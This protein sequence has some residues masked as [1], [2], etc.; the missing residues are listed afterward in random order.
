M[1]YAD[2]IKDLGKNLI[3]KLSKHYLFIIVL[4]LIA[5]IVAGVVTVKTGS[6]LD[7][8]RLVVIWFILPVMM[9]LFGTLAICFLERPGKKDPFKTIEEPNLVRIENN[10][11]EDL[12][13]T[14][15]LYTKTK[16]F[17]EFVFETSRIFLSVVGFKADRIQ[18]S[19]KKL[20]G[21]R[22]CRHI[23]DEERKICQELKRKNA[24]SSLNSLKNIC[25]TLDPD[26]AIVRL[27]M[28]THLLFKTRL[29][30]T[31]NLRI[32]YFQF[33]DDDHDYLQT[34][35]SWNGT[36]LNCV[37]SPSEK[38]REKFNM[39]SSAAECL[40]V[41]VALSGCIEP[42]PYAEDADGNSSHPFNYF[43]NEQ[44]EHIK[45]LVVIPLKVE[46]TMPDFKP[47]LVIDSDQPGFFGEFK[48]KEFKYIQTNLSTR[49]LM[50]VDMKVLLE[51]LLKGEYDNDNYDT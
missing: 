24:C 42:V 16:Q 34:P 47:L 1:S 48:E 30:P 40:A 9:I 45:S 26:E 4:V 19:Y 8:T 10:L 43:G 11:K 37:R 51:R 50:E 20:T 13:K 38:Y 14:K 21:Q 15:I 41:S 31:S 7:T 22:P 44:R 6:T 29:K 23:T 35:L 46:D 17:L 39:K 25:K 32:A 49:L 28:N 33:D 12:E 36:S 5:L 3:E 18:G 2:I 27:I